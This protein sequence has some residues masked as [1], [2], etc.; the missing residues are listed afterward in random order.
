MVKHPWGKIIGALLG[1]IVAGPL[2][3]I[4]GYFIGKSY[5][6]DDFNQDNVFSRLRES[7]YDNFLEYAEQAA[8]ALGVIVL[9]AKMARAD[10]TVRTE[11]IRAFKR[12]FNI[13]RSQEF[14]VSQIFNRARTSPDGFEPYAVRLA[15][16]FRDRP[17][18]LEGVLSGLFIIGAADGTLT[19]RE[20][21]YLRQ[22]AS[23]FGFDDQ[24]FARIAARAGVEIPGAVKPKS[25]AEEFYAV[26]GVA[27][28]CSNA[29]IK[30]AYR[31]LIREHHPDKLIAQGVPPEFIAAATEQMKRINAAYDAVCKL[32][33]IR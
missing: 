29:E 19:E 20:L 12:V 25:P 21:N 3:A 24:A 6:R 9:S 10:G 8:F 31:A 22:V 15:F 4:C 14:A 16:I 18:V 11:E 5:E 33:G 13:D 17:L 32:R 2:G 23:I 7:S 28:T 30:A 1:F 26:L 27:E